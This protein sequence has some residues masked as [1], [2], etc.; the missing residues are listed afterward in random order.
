MSRTALLSVGLTTTSCG[1]IGVP[2]VPC[3]RPHADAFADAASM[4]C[5]AQNACNRS[6]GSIR[7]PLRLLWPRPSRQRDLPRAH[8]LAASTSPM[9]R[10]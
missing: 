3:L 7:P 1:S 4:C 8:L 5:G 2:V 10:C 6:S 9:V